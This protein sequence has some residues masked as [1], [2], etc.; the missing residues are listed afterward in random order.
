MLS[1]RGTLAEPGQD[2]GR[3]ISL[4]DLAAFFPDLVIFKQENLKRHSVIALPTPA[5]RC[6]RSADQN[7]KYALNTNTSIA[8]AFVL[9]CL[10]NR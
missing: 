9:G 7:Q 2:F 5:S 3:P 8:L 6:T 4:D 10:H 1:S